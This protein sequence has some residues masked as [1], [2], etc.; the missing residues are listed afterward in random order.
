M[1]V[2]IAAFIGL[3]DGKLAVKTSDGYHYRQ[4]DRQTDRRPLSRLRVSVQY[5]AR[6]PHI[7]SSFGEGRLK[8]SVCLPRAGSCAVLSCPEA[9]TVLGI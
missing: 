9:Q 5:R 7:G 1:L 6:S 8:L 4:R 2:F 3:T